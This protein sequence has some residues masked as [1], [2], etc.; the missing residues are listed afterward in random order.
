V[1]RSAH[2][3]DLNPRRGPGNSGHTRE[4]DAGST[5]SETQRLSISARARSAAKV[6]THPAFEP[7]E[8]GRSFIMH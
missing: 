5:G 4:E 7:S 8:A 2:R 3:R 6:A 1:I